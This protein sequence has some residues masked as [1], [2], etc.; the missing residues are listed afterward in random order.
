MHL[1]ASDQEVMDMHPFIKGSLKK[2][3]KLQPLVVGANVQSGAFAEYKA[4]L[5]ALFERVT[6]ERDATSCTAP[7]APVTEVSSA[8]DSVRGTVINIKGRVNTFKSLLARGKT[9]S[10]VKG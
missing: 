3:M 10:P 9:L 6:G 1:Y 8:K 2:L 7:A 5:Q 4:K